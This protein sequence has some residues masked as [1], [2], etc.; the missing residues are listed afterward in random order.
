MIWLRIILLAGAFAGQAVLLSSAYAVDFD[1]DIR[2]ILSNNCFEC[3]G[4]DEKNRDGELRLDR[5]NSAFAEHDEV[6]RIVPGKPADSELFRRIISSDDDVRM[7]P[8]DSGHTLTS[9]QVD[10]IEQW[11][12]AGAEW[13]EHWSFVVPVVSPIPEVSNPEWISNPIDAFVLRR[14]DEEGF[15]PSARADRATLIRRVTQDITGLPPT[16]ADVDAFLA[17]ESPKAWERVV[18]R[19]LASPAFGEQMAVRWLDLARYAD[20]SGYQNDGPRDMWRWRDW[21][22][23]AYNSNMPF[24][25]FTIEQLAG[26]ML[27]PLPLPGRLGEGGLQVDARQLQRWI[28]TGFN[29]N[30]RGNAEGGVD[31]D[32]YQVEYVVDRVDTTATAWLGLTMGCARCHDHKYDP[33]TQREFYRVFACFNN[34]PEYGRAIKDGNSPPYIKAPTDEQQQH[35]QRLDDTIS[36]LEQKW[37]QLEVDRVA[38]QQEWEASLTADDSINWL[39]DD[40]ITARLTFDGHLSNGIPQAEVEVSDE[41]TE[42]NSPAV[43]LTKAEDAAFVNGRMGQALKLDGTS[44]VT[45]GDI[46]AFDYQDSI[47]WSLWVKAESDGTLMGRK[48]PPQDTQGYSLGILNGHVYVT[49]VNRWL[50]DSIRLTSEEALPFNEWHHV[51][52]TY[53][54]SRQASGVSVYID[55][56]LCRKS[57]QHD[58]LNQTIASPEPLRVGTGL[59]EFKGRVDELR[60]YN[61]CLSPDE[62]SII[63]TPNDVAVIAGRLP[64]DRTSGQSNKIAAAFLA[65]AASE[66]IRETHELLRQKRTERSKLIASLPT[67][68]VMHDSAPRKTF[69]L[70]RG[71]FDQPGSEVSAGIPAVLAEGNP[72]LADG[73]LGF[74]RWLVS[75]KHPLTARVAVNRYWQMYFGNGIVRTMED[76]GAQGSRPTHPELLDWLATEFVRSGWDIKAIH[77]RIVMSSTYQQ[78]SLAGEALRNQDPE[79]RLLARGPRFRL[80]AEQVRDQALAVSGLLHREIGGPSVKIYQP[81]GLWSEFSTDT[82]YE[83]AEGPDLYRRSLYAYWKRTVAPPAMITFDATAREMCSVRRAHT[84]TP[85]QALALMND[86]TYVEASRVLAERMIRE[87]GSETNERIKKGFRLLLSRQPSEAELELLRQSVAAYGMQFQTDSRAAAHLIALGES[88]PAEGIE[89]TQLAAWTMLASVLLNLDEAVTRR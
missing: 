53:D 70:N 86:V 41:S 31:P 44:P 72:A 78:N 49:L 10:L 65:K 40:G 64:A 19:L 54:G 61:H 17:D 75:G 55:G 8:V 24:D 42:T 37:S 82:E 29:R 60:V 62:I 18:D 26:D 67:I 56:K 45:V 81:G 38:A 69:V 50:D 21:V 22:I 33:I 9:D 74:A 80:T 79:N 77:K 14:L 15:S 35:L 46:G 87:G 3:H 66:S 4:P 2:P 39:Y 63:A 88:A 13:K 48:K 52:M 76:F 7:P 43:A 68:M 16:L 12:A 85:T 28:A 71:Q 1:R 58:F 11:I 30:H 83:L 23:N 36:Q 20:T 32:E 6:V 47:T 51:A 57:I 84:N 59:G 73:R 34:I 5:R 89:P 25:Q 27:E